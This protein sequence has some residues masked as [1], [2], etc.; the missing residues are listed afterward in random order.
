M[1]LG[2]GKTVEIV[3]NLKKKKKKIQALPARGGSQHSGRWRQRQSDLCE[4]EAN[5][6]CRVEFQ[7]G[8]DYTVKPCLKK[9]Q[10][11]G[12]EMAQQLR[13]LTDCSSRGPEFNSHHMVAQNHLQ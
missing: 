1:I 7:D 9:K 10:N 2:K 4:F 12:G 3:K 6:I 11:Q 8:Q 5:L 13:G